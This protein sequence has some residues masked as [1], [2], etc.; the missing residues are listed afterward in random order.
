MSHWK[1]CHILRRRWLLKASWAGGDEGIF[2]VQEIWCSSDGWLWSRHALIAMASIQRRSRER[3]R[4]ISRISY[5]SWMAHVHRRHRS[6]GSADIKG[7]LNLLRQRLS[8]SDVGYV[9]LKIWLLSILLTD[10]FERFFRSILNIF[11]INCGQVYVIRKSFLGL[12]MRPPIFTIRQKISS[13]EMSD[14]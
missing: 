8:V 11:F 4:L 7:K 1:W 12:V 5:T 6:R 2:A 3:S 13:S 14:I 10:Y 9:S